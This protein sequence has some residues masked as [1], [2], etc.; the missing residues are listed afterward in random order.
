MVLMLAHYF[1]LCSLPWFTN[2]DGSIDG[3]FYLLMIATQIC[4]QVER[5]PCR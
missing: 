4:Q 1:V 5:V 3:L 2:A